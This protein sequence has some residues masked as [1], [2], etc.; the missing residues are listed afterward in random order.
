MHRMGS[1]PH[2]TWRIKWVNWSFCSFNKVD[3]EACWLFS[4]WEKQLASDHPEFRCQGV[5]ASSP[6]EHVGA[7][8]SR[9]EIQAVSCE[10][11]I[12]INDV[13]EVIMLR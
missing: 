10:T 5:Q 11:P 7:N 3:N 12:K 9:Y 13:T 6:M 1:N 2:Q 4:E 8:N